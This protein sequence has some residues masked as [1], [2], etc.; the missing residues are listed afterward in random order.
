MYRVCLDDYRDKNTHLVKR[1]VSFLHEHASFRMKYLL[2][3]I[4]Y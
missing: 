2:V 3:N 1:Y 4:D